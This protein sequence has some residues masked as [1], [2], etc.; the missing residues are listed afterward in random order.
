MSYCPPIDSALFA[1]VASDFDLTAPTAVQELREIL[2]AIKESA[3][4]Q[5]NHP[6]DPSGTANIGTNDPDMELQSDPGASPNGGCTLPTQTDATSLSLGSADEDG[7]KN[8]RP[9]GKSRSTNTVG[10][11][12]SHASSGATHDENVEALVEMFPTLSRLDITQ[13][14]KK[15]AGDPTKTMDVLL[16]L[17]FFDEVQ[18][19]SDD[20]QI[21]VPKG[22]DGFLAS[23]DVDIGLQKGRRKKR[24]K[25]HM[26]RL[27]GIDSS[28]NGPLNKWE[29][30]KV[31]IDFICSRAPGISR[32]KVSS[33]Y[34]AHAVSLPATIRAIALA[35]SPK[36]LGEIDDDPVMLTQVVEL[37]GAYPEFQTTILIG[38]LRITHNMP[39]AANELAAVLTRQPSL[40][41]VSNIVKFTASPLNLDEVDDGNTDRHNGKRRH[42]VENTLETAFDHEQAQAAAEVQFAAGSAAYQQAA[43]AARRA[44]SNH[45]YGGASA[46]YRQVGQERRELAM[47]QLSLA[48]DRLVEW[49]SSNGYIDLHGVT[50]DNAIRITR[51]RVAAW[52]DALGDRKH[53]RGGGKHVH[54]G[55]KVVT[56]AGRHSRDGTSR[57]GPAVSKML[58]EEG[59]RV[60]IDRGFLTVTGRART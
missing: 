49:Q 46:Y 50:V 12:G 45:L 43:E 11:N 16:N 2:D 40:A 57:L 13:S 59:W 28:N 21:T 4:Q 19:A 31:D 39:S 6:F 35:S 8:S 42:N 58:L 33:T 56:G 55:F 17:A 10:A 5:E 51:D 37:A 38:L 47:Q 54:G 36:Q 23:N 44:K 9:K 18:S 60:E 20:T 52:W 34:H 15:S 22:I 3:L 53:V 7:S 24:N 26:P 27:E 1:A 41:E 29:M 30:A 14:L 48:S 32:E 25:K